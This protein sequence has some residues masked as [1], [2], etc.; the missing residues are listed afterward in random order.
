MYA[1][2][3]LAAANQALWDRIRDGVSSV[4]ET[5]TENRAVPDQIPDE[6]VFTQVCGFPLFRRYRGQAVILGIPRYDFEGC[7]GIHHRAA[8]IVRG[9]DPATDLAS[10]RGRV[11]GCNSEQSNT[12]MNLPRLSLSRVAGGSGR[13][14]SNVVFTSS[15]CISLSCLAK[16]TIDLCS[17]DC[18]TWGLLQRYYPADTAGLRVLEW[19][20]PSPC[21]PFVTSVA[22]PHVIG[23]ALVANLLGQAEPGLG[24]VGVE[25]ADPAAYDILADYEQEAA[26]HGYPALW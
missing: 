8:F 3:A 19:T 20:E 15:H 2:S 5:L 10:F 16:R 9:D 7:D 17:V 21:L 22:T 18:V 14:F 13:F 4:P 23:A 6:T 1:Y 26:A 25:P 12:G 11:F 24:L